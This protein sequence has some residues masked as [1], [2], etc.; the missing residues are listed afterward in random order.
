[1]VYRYSQGM[2]ESSLLKYVLIVLICILGLAFTL[3]FLLMIGEAF[4]KTNRVIGKI[5]SLEECEA[6]GLRERAVK[7]TN[8]LLGTRKAIKTNDNSRRNAYQ[9]ASIRLPVETSEINNTVQPI[10]SNW[11]WYIIFISKLVTSNYFSLMNKYGC[12]NI[13]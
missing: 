1:M 6:Y 3:T 5:Y 7:T 10:A 12:R 4:I 13:W 2:Y 9:F 11:A 8:R